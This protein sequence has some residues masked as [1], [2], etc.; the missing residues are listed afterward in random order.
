[1]LRIVETC[2]GDA[3]AVSTT[4]WHLLSP[5]T[6]VTSCAAVAADCH[7]PL[8]EFRVERRDEAVCAGVGERGLA[9]HVFR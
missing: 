6:R 4:D 3:V 9:G 2:V 5:S 8:E 7:T 1:M